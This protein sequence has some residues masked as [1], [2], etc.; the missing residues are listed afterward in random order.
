[1]R[2]TDV[3]LSYADGK[4]ALRELNLSIAPGERVAIIGP[5]GAG[6]TSLLHLLASQLRPSQG[7]VELLGQAPWALSARQRQTLRSQIGLIQQ[8]PPLPAKQR[9]ITAVLAGK[10][11]QWSTAKGLLS[12]LYPLDPD[13]AAAALGQLDLA[14]KLYQRCDQ[15]SGGQLQ[16]VA[17][18]RV[19]Y[20]QPRLIL[21]DEPVSAMDPVLAD[22]AL[23][24]LH[25]YAQRQGSTLVASLHNVELALSHFAR[26]I[27]VRDGQ[28]AF[29]QATATV[30]Q[31][32]LDG[33]YANQ[34][35]QGSPAQ[36][37]QL[38][39]VPRQIPRC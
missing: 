21:A 19:L 36:H 13:G 16:R 34:Q 10:L 1:M 24:Q 22:H 20:Q 29:D 12:L 35:L 18:A 31:A 38:A 8:S 17:I 28:I 25:Q 33:L 5:S 11:G 32:D 37:T 7:L 23:T 9:V 14:D 39:P 3:G 27:G 6:K 2:L 15:L 26:V 30:S 4:V